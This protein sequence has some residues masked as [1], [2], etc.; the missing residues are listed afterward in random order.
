MS[1]VKINRDKDRKLY[2]KKYIKTDIKKKDNME[3]NDSTNK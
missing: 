1:L 2:R 3:Q